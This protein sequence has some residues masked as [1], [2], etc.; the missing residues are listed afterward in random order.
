MNRSESISKL[1]A[2]LIKF[3]SEVTK[4]S[5]DA[6]NPFH[7]STYASLDNIIDAVRPILAK[8]DLN[9]MQF[10]SSDGAN[11]VLKTML[12]H[13]SGEY[14]ES[15]PL[16]LKPVKNDPQGM[17]SALTYARRYSLNAFLNLN[18]GD[19]DDAN[20]ASGKQNKQQQQ[21]PQQQN[22]NQPKKASDAQ[23]KKLNTII[24]NLCK[25]GGTPEIVRNALKEKKDIGPFESMKDLTVGQASKAIKYVEN[26]TKSKEE[27]GGN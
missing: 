22:N 14:I 2:S 6:A 27:N 4:V 5:K 25:Y 17:G 1:S 11:I 7:K 26:W 20:A 23:I 18:T 15:E 21:P 3:N 19:D 13:S 24:T 12:I 16:V 9:I 10:P 8:N